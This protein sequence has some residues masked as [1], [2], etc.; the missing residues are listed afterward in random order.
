[1]TPFLWKVGTANAFSTTL[2]GGITDTDVTINLTSVTGLQAPGVLVIDRLDANNTSTPV[3]REYISFTDIAGLAVTGCTRELGGSLAQSHSSGAKVE[4]VWS[5]THVNDLIDFLNVS[6]DSAGKIVTS[7]ATIIDARITNSLNVS[8]ASLNGNFPITPTWVISGLM[9]LATTSIGPSVS[10][11][12][13]GVWQFFSATLKTPASGASFILDFNKNGT[14]IFE[15]GT[16]PY[17]AGGGTFVS[18]ASINTKTF[19]S[20]DT[21]TLDIDSGAGTGSDLTFLGRAY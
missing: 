12:Q 16:R 9:S 19:S 17:I 4:E 7:S 1:M 20:G 11:P 18:T 10:M 8:G 2:N 14:S 6:H 5:I 13:P 21:F 15:S 3:T